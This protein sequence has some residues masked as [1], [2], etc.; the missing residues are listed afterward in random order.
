MNFNPIHRARL[1]RELDLV[2]AET[3]KPN[4]QF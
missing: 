4:Q 2:A 3:P 1:P